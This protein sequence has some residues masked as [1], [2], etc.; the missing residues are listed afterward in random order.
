MSRT[1][2]T[3]VGVACLLVLF[4]QLAT[5]QE[6]KLNARDLYKQTVRGMALILTER[7]TGSAWIVDREKK[8]LIT[9]FHVVMTGPDGSLRFAGKEVSVVFP[10][11]QDGKL[12][13]ERKYYLESY[14]QR[15]VK[16]RVL[17]TNI[18]RDLALIQL[19]SL[20]DDARALPLAASSPEPAENIH[21]VGNPAA[22]SALWVYTLGT[23]RT[24]HK[25]TFRTDAGGHE[26]QVIE[27]QA[28]V[29]PGDSGGPVLNDAGEVVGVV[30]SK[31][32][33]K[34][35]VDLLSYCI[36]LSEVRVFLEIA[37]QAGSPLDAYGYSARAGN[38]FRQRNWQAAIADHTKAIELDPKYVP[39]YVGR[40]ASLCNSNQFERATADCA[41]AIRLDANN[42][43]AY[44]TRCRTH[45][46]LGKISLAISDATRA[47]ELGYR[48]PWLY[49]A[50]GY[51]YG[52]QNRRNDALRDYDKAIE[53]SP[54]Y[55]SAYYNRAQTRWALNDFRG[56]MRDFENVLR[57]A[58]PEDP[59]LIQD[60]RSEM[61]RLRQIPM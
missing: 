2:A 27:T 50:R 44:A 19:D 14:Q 6:R 59:S 26:F 41:E 30:Q 36:D 48:E 45:Q 24:V 53:L 4:P 39:A 52:Q 8:Q 51:C 22:S 25:K 32:G 16:G 3:L 28:P 23:V 46:A 34:D 47:I 58:G 10:A 5:G 35:N 15:A 20:P 61:E 49:Y 38:H 1:A 55:A 11:Y 40:A 57:V 13:L 18:E 33:V 9:N 54:N 56:A 29:N 12:I 17:A 42:K 43:D 60:A 31:H 37:R 21:S 7:T